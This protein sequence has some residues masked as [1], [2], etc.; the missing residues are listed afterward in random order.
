MK[1][2]EN[3]IQFI[4]SIVDIDAKILKCKKYIKENYNIDCIFYP[5][6]MTLQ[7][8]SNNINEGLDILNSKDY[9]YS[10]FDEDIISIEY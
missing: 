5:E 9:I 7:L 10:I 4:K 6:T 3:D 1:I 8:F 2:T